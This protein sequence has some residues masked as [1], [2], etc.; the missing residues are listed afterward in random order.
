MINIESLSYWCGLHSN[1]LVRSDG[2][3]TLGL[4]VSESPNEI[5]VDLTGVDMGVSGIRFLQILVLRDLGSRVLK[6]WIVPSGNVSGS[7]LSTFGPE[8][9]EMYGVSMGVMTRRRGLLL[10][11]GW[12]GYPLRKDFPLSGYSELRWWSDSIRS[13]PI[14]W[15]VHWRGYDK[16]EDW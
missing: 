9:E 7:S 8:L 2:V 16:E 3:G 11:S 13:E 5:C 12:E 1:T 14:D 6:H 4:H 15:L 10:D